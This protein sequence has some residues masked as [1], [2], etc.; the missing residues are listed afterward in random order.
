MGFLFLFLAA[1]TNGRGQTGNRKRCITDNQPKNIISKIIEFLIGGEHVGNLAFWEMAFRN[2][3]SER[4]ENGVRVGR[5]TCWHRL[6]L[7]WRQSKGRTKPGKLRSGHYCLQNTFTAFPHFS[8]KR[9]LW[10]QLA[11]VEK[12][13][14]SNPGLKFHLPSCVTLGKW[15]AISE[16]Q[17]PQLWNG[18][19]SWT[20][21]SIMILF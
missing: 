5:C 15:L 18:N 12:A 8:L 7:G 19:D 21:P 3:G 9:T 13:L 6:N 2:F 14:G 11:L 20:V 16:P 1:P 4:I 17:C 10:E